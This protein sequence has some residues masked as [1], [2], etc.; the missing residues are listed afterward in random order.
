MYTKFY[1]FKKK[2]IYYKMKWHLHDKIKSTKMKI[3]ILST[4]VKQK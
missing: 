2:K 3:K 1:T 4:Q